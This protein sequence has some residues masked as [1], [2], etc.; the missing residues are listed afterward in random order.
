[1]R[2]EPECDPTV[3]SRWRPL[4]LL[5]SAMDADIARLYDEASIGGMKPSFVMELLRLNAAGQMTITELAQSVHRTHSAA[6]QKVS[7]M[8]RAGLVRTRPGT[9]ARSKSVVLTTKAKRLA[10][11]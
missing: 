5:L 3:H 7:A 8:Q 10:A 11:T 1:M 6:S 4:R 2:A 9:D